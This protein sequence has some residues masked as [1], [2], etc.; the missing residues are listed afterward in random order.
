MLCG[1]KMGWPRLFASWKVYP[2]KK[3]GGKFMKTFDELVSEAWEAPFSGWDFSWQTGRWLTRQPSWNYP[4]LARARLATATS[5]LDQGTGG[6]EFLSHLVPFPPLTCATEGYPPNVT[7]AKA[8]LAPLDVHVIQVGN[9]QRLPFHNA[10]FDVILNRHE[11]FSAGEALRLLKPGGIFLTQQVGGR[12]CLRLNELLQDQ[13]EFIYSDWTLEY[14]R[15]QV[16]EVG[17]N[18]LQARE[19]LIPSEFY[20]IGAVVYY[21]KVIAWQVEGFSPDKYRE[22]LEK[23]DALIRKEGRLTVPEDRFLIEAQKPLSAP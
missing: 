4:A 3:E 1:A 9:E 6:G 10:S 12:N 14:V 8:R 2:D 16:E 22:R 19:E 11:G 7:V 15:R 18:I 23:I 13:V 21:L 20:D 17:L 5:A